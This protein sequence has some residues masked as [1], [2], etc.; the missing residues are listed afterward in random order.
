MTHTLQLEPI[1]YISSSMTLKFE[2]PHQPD[3]D[4]NDTPGIIELLPDRNFD[5]ALHDL[6][7]F[8]YIWILWW[9]HKNTTWKPK[10]RPPRGPSE[11]RGLFATRS[12]HRPN[13]IG[14]SAVRL[15]GIE[16]RKIIIGEHDLIEGTPILDIKPYIPAVDAFPD[17]K[18][19][20]VKDI[21]PLTSRFVISFTPE[22]R[23]Q[24]EWL[25]EKRVAFLERSEMLLSHDPSPHKT[26]RIKKNKNRT[27]TMG[28]GAWRIIFGIT[29]LEV[30]IL[31]YRPGYPQR[32]LDQTEW[33]IPD[34]DVQKAFLDRFG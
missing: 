12:P 19:G 15:L 6:E 4:V 28:C 29:D 22:A 27:F 5:K 25:K 30:I 2:A 18:L 11:K 17:A 8:E 1:G 16:D 24:R 26:R 33:E 34:G 23:L 21:Q 13:P 14:L 20:W 7:G 10:V 9:F 31:S 32:L 3:A